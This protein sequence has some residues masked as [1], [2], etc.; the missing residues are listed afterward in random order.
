ARTAKELLVRPYLTRFLREGDENVWRVMVNNDAGK[1]LSGRVE[2]A[3]TDPATGADLAAAFGL[4]SKSA[5]FKV[6]AGRSATV[7]FALSV[8][9]RVSPVA[10][11]VKGVAGDLSD[12]E[13]HLVPVLPSRVRVSE[14][15]FAYLDAPGKQTLAFAAP[16]GD[17]A[18]TTEQLVVTV[19]GQLFY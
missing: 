10:V 19:D 4:K 6:G 8:P 3:I 15:R 9:D 1:A 16:K 5:P 11:T 12:G 2:L 14:S 17:K 13:R 18:F 7:A